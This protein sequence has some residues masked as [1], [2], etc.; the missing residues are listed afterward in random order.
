MNETFEFALAN[1]I[2]EAAALTSE[3]EN[4]NPALALRLYTQTESLARVS[5]GEQHPLRA[6]ALVGMGIAFDLQGEPEVAK[7]L[8][9]AGLAL[10][11]PEHPAYGET[12]LELAIT[13]ER[14]GELDAA[15]ERYAQALSHLPANEAAYKTALAALM[16]IEVLWHAEATAEEDT[17]D[18]S[19]TGQTTH[20]PHAVVPPER[21]H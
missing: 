21:L 13:H 9:S 4:A 19:A 11:D 6:L 18:E 20:H 12:L 1:L 2:G 15:Y 10:L 5:L 7:R 14:L 17:G 3:S 16:R 8:C